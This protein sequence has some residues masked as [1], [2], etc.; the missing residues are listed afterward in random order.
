MHIAVE[1]ILEKIQNGRQNS[2][3]IFFHSFI[4]FNYMLVPMI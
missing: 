3:V 2:Q 1:I 4:N